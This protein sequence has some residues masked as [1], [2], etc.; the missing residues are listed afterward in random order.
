MDATVIGVGLVH[1]TVYTSGAHWSWCSSVLR[2]VGGVGGVQAMP[3]HPMVAGMSGHHVHS[4]VEGWC[5]V[6]CDQQVLPG[7][8]SGPDID[9]V[10][11]IAS[12][13]LAAG[14]QEIESGFR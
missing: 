14:G 13:S 12:L 6:A 8:Q 5:S 1:T 3:G 9:A 10:P 2:C 4:V 7:V 11:H